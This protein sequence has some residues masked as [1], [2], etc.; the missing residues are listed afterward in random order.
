LT[1]DGDGVPPKIV[2]TFSISRNI[3]S[4]NSS[5]NY[6]IN[7]VAKNRGDIVELLKAKGMDMNNNRFLILQGEVEQI[8]LMKPISG[9]REDPGLLEYLEDIIGSYKYVDQIMELNETLIEVRKSKETEML[10]LHDMSKELEGMAESKASAIAYFEIEKKLL[11]LNHLRYYLELA[12]IREQ[13]SRLHQLIERLQEELEADKKKMQE[14]LAVYKEDFLV[15]KR[16]DAKKTANKVEAEAIDDSLKKASEEDQTYQSRIRSILTESHDMEGQIKKLHTDVKKAIENKD[17]KELQLPSKRQE[18]A[19]VKE[20]LDRCLQQEAEILKKIE[21]QITS[22][23][24]KKE[25]LNEKKAP[26]ERELKKQEDH[27]KNMIQE[28]EVIDKRDQQI[29]VDIERLE[30]DFGE[31]HKIIKRE[32]D[33]CEQLKQDHDGHKQK[34][35]ALQTKLKDLEEKEGE[36]SKQLKEIDLV[37]DERRH[38]N[39]SG[40]QKNQVL[41]Y[42]MQNK[43]IQEKGGR[44][45]G[46]IGDLG[47]IDPKF[48]IAFSS[49]SPKFNHILVDTM[50]TMTL[51]IKLLKKDRV[52]VA[53]MISLEA[54]EGLRHKMNEPF[55][56]P[57]QTVRLFDVVQKKDDAAKLAFYF[58]LKDSITC[59]NLDVAQQVKEH[60]G[61]RYHIVTAEGFIITPEGTMS[62]GGKPR[63]GAVLLTG[64][65]AGTMDEEE[66]PTENLMQK[67]DMLSSTLRMAAEEKESTRKVISQTHQ[68]MSRIPGTI[69]SLEETIAKENASLNNLQNKQQNLVKEKTDGRLQQ[70]RKEYQ[71]EIDKIHKK[72]TDIVKEQNKIKAMQDEL[73]E[74]IEQIGGRSLKEIKTQVTNYR[75]THEAA[76]KHVMEIEAQIN[77]TYKNIE[78][79]NKEIEELNAKTKK[80]EE[81]KVNL[82]KLKEECEIKARELFEKKKVCMTTE[83]EIET[84]YKELEEKI[85]VMT[86]TIDKLKQSAKAKKEEQVDATKKQE[87]IREENAKIMDKLKANKRF[88][89]NFV[90]NYSMIEEIKKI[91]KRANSQASQDMS[92]ITR[93]ATR[94]QMNP[95][96]DQFTPD[97]DLTMEE[98]KEVNLTID[99]VKSQI[100]YH[101]QQRDQLTGDIE[102]IETYREKLSMFVK[103]DGDYK[104]I[105]SKEQLIRTDL[106]KLK[107]NR[108]IEFMTGFSFISKKLKEVYQTITNGGDADLEL[109]DSLDP[110]SEGIMFSVRPPHKSWKHMSKLS[111]GEK[112]LSSL[113]LIFA[114]HYY[115]P[116]P[117]YF[118]DEIDAAL[119]FRNV[120]IVGKFIKERTKDAQFIVISLRNHMFE[121][122]NQL[123]GIYKVNDMTRTISIY[124]YQFLDQINED[125][126]REDELRRTQSMQRTQ[127]RSQLP[128]KTSIAITQDNA[129][130]LSKRKS[131]AAVLL[132]RQSRPM[133]LPQESLPN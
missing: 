99:F 97:K 34:I 86:A 112:T 47:K 119:D 13:D 106:N 78:T 121:L 1:E 58:V 68:S 77:Q 35:V 104:D 2:E 43:E 70:A 127:L 41:M 105:V 40:V 18:E 103:K 109:I 124:P 38:K 27:K 7:G 128:S 60:Q 57:P 8:S 51:C 62:G 88:Y 46:R 69:K 59:A 49:V 92:Q 50:D 132:N 76:L 114:L 89:L 110:F 39:N 6:E 42:L 67:K 79:K 32:A 83:K 63:T 23:R 94:A 122:A 111:G 107:E 61:R 101:M 129:S 108:R 17:E 82:I 90:A 64:Q 14:S 54:L 130:N 52:G 80:N 120:E 12:D 93:S 25:E 56:A 125:M 26:I 53:R 126:R 133:D 45:Y 87:A 31:C 44:I 123:I 24:Q 100:A 3:F 102:V 19:T 33:K 9:K 85:K 84:E 66:I 4:E 75:S 29:D 131:M 81:E 74:N 48:D 36:L 72:I 71:T 113:S 98:I 73:D 37:L 116:T 30:K 16:L 11:T 5:S 15:V 118:M 21:P 22:I 55:Q 65:S 20:A 96:L 10:M 115:K 91:E 117:I 95:A 28:L